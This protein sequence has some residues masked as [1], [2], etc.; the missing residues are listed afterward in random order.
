MSEKAS[1]K[2]RTDV[3]KNIKRYGRAV[4][5]IFPDQDM[6]DPTNEVFAYSIGNALKGLPELL[7]VGMYNETAKQLINI[8]SEKQ[9]QR[10][11][12]FD[13]GELVSLGGK[14]PVLVVAAG[15]EVKERYTIQVKNFVGEPYDV[16]QIVMCDKEGRFPGQEGCAPP[17]A[18]V[19]VYRRAMH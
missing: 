17:Y 14:H 8:L 5:G 18:N 7:I 12:A 6:K 4:F 19:R 9:L 15:D 1:R 16:M 3:R 10:G 11:H 13:D 2:F